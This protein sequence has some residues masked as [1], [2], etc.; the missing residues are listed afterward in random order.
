MKRVFKLLAAAALT[1]ALVGSTFLQVIESC[2]NS[3]TA[4]SAVAGE[5]F[6]PP[7]GPYAG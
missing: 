5:V 7:L 4:S 1:F 3:S 2:P 6:P